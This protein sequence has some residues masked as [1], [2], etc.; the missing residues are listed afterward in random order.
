MHHLKV[1]CQRRSVET[2]TRVV[3]RY[4]SL[5]VVLSIGWLRAISFGDVQCIVWLDVSPTIWMVMVAD[6]TSAVFERGAT[7]IASKLN[8]VHFPMA[9]SYPSD[10]PLL[11]TETAPCS[12]KSYLFLFFAANC[13][14]HATYMAFFGPSFVFGLSQQ[15][16]GDAWLA[17]SC[18]AQGHDLPF[19]NSTNSSSL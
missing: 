18:T 13:I 7:L 4:C 11:D 10:H 2:P 1:A 19:G 8:L 16:L 5:A 12:W 9:S 3:H 6:A 17:S 14:I 15:A